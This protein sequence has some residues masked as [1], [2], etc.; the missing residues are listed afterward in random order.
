MKILTAIALMLASAEMG[1][2]AL[3]QTVTPEN[4]VQSSRAELASDTIQEIAQAYHD[5]GIFDGVIIVATTERV[6]Y[7]GAFGTANVEFGVRYQQDTR[8]RLASVS[9]PFAAAIVLRLEEDDLLSTSQTVAQVLPELANSPF[10]GV[11]IDQL[12]RHS[13]GIPNYQYRAPFQALQ[14]KVL[15]SGMG[16]I[17]VTLPDMIATFKDEPLLFEPG[18]RYDYSNGNYILIQ[19]IIEQRSGMPFADALKTFVTGPLGMTDTGALDYR[20]IRPRLA[21]GYFSAPGGFEA[22][23]Q[24]QFVGVPAVGGIYSSTAD[25]ARW[26]AALFGERFFKHRETLEKMTTPRSKAHDAKSF[27][28][29][30][31][32]TTMLETGEGSVNLIGHDG[33]GPPFTANLQYSPSNNLIVFAADS[34]GGLGGATD[35]ETVRMA[36][37][38]FR[39]ANGAAWEKPARPV[40]RMLADLINTHGRAEGLARFIKAEPELSG[41]S[42]AEREIN[43]LGYAY[44]GSGKLDESVAVFQLNTDLFAQSAN[45]FDSLGEALE[46]QGDTAAALTALLKAQT[47]QPENARYAETVERL[48]SEMAQD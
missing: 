12:L 2:V 33:W 47:L 21:Q 41:S 35:G 18:T 1:N 6:L 39:A 48:Q 30:G 29:Y 34:I 9:K 13:S 23:L 24:A 8:V 26:F 22:P 15:L 40:D 25:M 43:R 46:A 11:T 38:I 3:A 17:T 19:A 7:S 37:T 42:S 36:E 31:L 45:A 10:A 44:L 28:G 4:T 32:F 27:I 16:S 14:S 5:A 20:S